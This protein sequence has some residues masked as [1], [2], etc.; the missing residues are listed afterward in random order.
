MQTVRDVV[1]VGGGP[2][3]SAAA[4]WL[5]RE[6]MD[7]A[8]YDRASFPRDKACGEFLT[9]QTRVLLEDLGAWPAICRAGVRPVCATVLATPDGHRF[10]HM[11]TCATPVGYALRRVTLDAVLLEHAC[12]S[13]VAVQ[14]GATVRGVLRDAT[15]R[16]CGVQVQ[17]ADGR[18]DT[19]R[20]R[21]V[22]AADGTH[23]RIARDMGLV[24]PIRRLQRVAV[25]T[26]GRVSG[27][28]TD[29]IEMRA[30]GPI[31]CGLGF[32]GGLQE[33][34]EASPV[35]NVTLVAPVTMAAHIA[36]RPRDF[37][38]QTLEVHFPDVAA[39]LAWSDCSLEVRTIGCFGHV[40]R[41]PLAEGVLLL[42]DAAT[43]IDPFTGEGVYFALR[44][45]QCAAE[46]ASAALRAGDLSRARLMTYARARR[47]LNLRYLLCDLVQAVVRRPALF[48]RVVH[49]LDT[50]PGL[51]ERLFAVLG[52][53]RPP[54]D[55]LH[56][57]FLWRVL[58]P[59]LDMTRFRPAG[60]GR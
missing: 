37:V 48:A 34:E 15:G 21:L 31:V 5:A 47:E 13:G 57:A 3:G 23:S 14:T 52:D 10:H 6:G 2:A 28:R 18:T 16:V 12:R 30:R 26:H 29:T 44:G 46:V 45:A 11:H 25:V 58:A 51:D 55:A 22:L 40:C 4:I 19:V 39:R 27:G 43:F 56:P 49:Q 9:P 53:R 32:P 60:A 17:S 59:G 41:P 50:V 7:V 54:S 24:R 33:G 8:L 36:G 42:G 20:A 38:L 1:V 35:A